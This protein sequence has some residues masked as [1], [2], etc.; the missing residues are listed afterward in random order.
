MDTELY[1]F[2]FQ[3]IDVVV[4]PWKILGIVGVLLFTGRWFVQ[5]WYSR[6]AGKPV[7]PRSFWISTWTRSTRITCIS[8][9]RTLR[10]LRSIGRRWTT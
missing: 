10:V 3:G 4:T 5:A 9:N 8:C 2:V 6:Q 7:T 1:K